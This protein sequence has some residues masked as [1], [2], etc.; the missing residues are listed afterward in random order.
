VNVAANAPASLTNQVTA[1][2]AGSLSPASTTDTT[3]I[4]SLAQLSITKS[5]AGSFTQ[6]QSGATYSVTVSNAASVAPTSGTVTVTETIPSG[7]TLVSMSGTGWTCAGNTCTRADSLSAGASYPAITITVNVSSTAPSSATNSVAVSGGG[8]ASA[9]A[10]DPT[11]IIPVADLTIT[12]SHSGNF[13]QGQTGAAYIIT[14]TNRGVGSTA[15]TVSVTDTLPAGLTATALAGTGWSC[16]VTPVSCARGDT[17]AAGS[18]YPAITLT[19]SVAANAPSSITNTATVSGGG[20]LNTGNNTASDS[21]TIVPLTVI[22]NVTSSSS[23][24]TYAAGQSI[25]IQVSFSQNVSVTGTPTLMLNSGGAA[26]YNSGSGTSILTFAYQVGSSDSSGH[27]DY[28]SSSALALNGGSITDA[29]SN[30]SV[31][32]LP[33]PGAA[34]SL[35]AN[36]SFVIAPPGMRFVAMPPC[37]VVDTRWPAGPFGAPGLSNNSRD[38]P[39]PNGSCGI[40]STA[41]AYALNV[42]VVPNGPVGYLSIWPT[43]RAQPFVSTLNSFDGRVKANAAIVPAGTNGSVSVYS[44]SVTDLLLDISGYFTSDPTQ[45]T[46]YPA[47]PCRVVDTRNPTG[48]FGGP[49]LSANET[50]S[51]PISSG[52]CNIPLNAAGYSLNITV[53]PHGPLAYLAA[54]PTGQAQSAATTLNAPTTAITANAAFVQA[55]TNGAISVNV[56]S[57]TTVVIDI[58]GYFAPNNG[59]GLSFYP[60]TPCRTMD[61]RNP[62]GPL[63]GPE[64]YGQRDFPLSTSSCG[65]PATAQ[66]YSLNATVVP[67]TVL[68][69]LSL[70]PTGL[71]MPVV[72]TLN[73]LDGS[74]VANAAIVPAAGGSISAYTNNPIALILDT[75]GYFG[76]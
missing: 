43:G 74:V 21:A 65:L 33:A 42:T 26:S 58:N 36:K 5:H 41:T 48:T 7:L 56:S 11:T 75:N 14:V 55:G 53:V 71:S 54:W 34:G 19:A 3:A 51:F 52:G 25:S 39:I 30:A 10:S 9:T 40:P 37:R 59:S 73:A 12:K 23:N 66:A 57:S 61:T 22:S 67:D 31:L 45:L 62:T 72:S 69:Y 46:F 8:S 20:E 49:D 18:S 70:W 64:L 32:T 15:G 47:T 44:N 35:G 16:N 27:L 13:I 17:L 2:G 24:G 6:G 63:G 60:V 50:R 4:I 28:A 29:A 1:S 68:G 38:F 76:P